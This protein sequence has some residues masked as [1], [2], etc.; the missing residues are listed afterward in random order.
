MPT[1][2]YPSR[3][4]RDAEVPLLE[5]GAP[6]MARAAAALARFSADVLR[7]RR[8]LVTGSRVCVLAG[9]G[10]NAGDALYA[11]AAL[12]R[13]GARVGVIVLFGTT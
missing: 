2:A 9:P 4:V 6:L 1:Y 7:A 13:L 12:A 8:G 3:T 11:A 10:N 5:A